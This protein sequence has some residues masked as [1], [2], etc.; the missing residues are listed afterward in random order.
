MTIL[1]LDTATRA[2]AV[3]IS[4]GAAQHFEARDDPPPG[5]R[6]RH[7]TRLLPMVAELFELAEVDWEDIDLLAVGVGPGTFTG[8]RVG[9]ATARALGQARRI[10]LVGVCTLQSL[11]VNA[12]AGADCAGTEAVLSVL[13]ARRGEAF[14]AAWR[15]GVLAAALG[16]D[17]EHAQPADRVAALVAPTTAG[18]SALGEL[19]SQVAPSALAIGE[20]A[21]EFRQVL[22]C[23][24]VSVPEDDS[25]LHRVTA[26][27][28]CRLARRIP[29]ADFAAVLPSYLRRPDAEIALGL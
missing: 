19:A 1:A 10:P 6:P 9:V 17:S 14:A 4:L 27:N 24:G 28:H 3:A 25:E 2:T 11:A 8:L 7:T 18:S 21:V 20:G 15:V 23:S 22:E 16:G 12:L 5:Q 29:S 26:I 13:D